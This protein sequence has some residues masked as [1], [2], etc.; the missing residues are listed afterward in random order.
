MF[1]ATS[2]GIFILA[3]DMKILA[4]NQAYSVITGRSSADAVGQNILELAGHKLKSQ[5]KNLKQFLNG[6]DRWQG[7]LTAKRRSG[8][9]FPIWLQLTVVRDRGGQITHYVG[10][11]ADLTTHRQTEEQLQYLTNYDALTQLA[12]RKLFNERLQQVAKRLSAAVQPQNLLARLSAD[13]FVVIVEHPENEQAL[14]MLANTLLHRLREPMLLGEQELVMTASIGISLFPATA[15][16]SLLLITQANQAMQHAKQLGGNNAQFF[17]HELR[18]YSL[19]QLQLENQLR[20]ALEDDQLIVYYQPKLHLATDRIRSA[21]ALVRWQH[22]ER[23]LVMPGE[24]INIAEESG[25]IV[26]LGDTVLRQACKQ[27]SQWYREGPTAVAVSVNLSVQQLRQE[28]FAQD[29]A[30]ILQAT[31][32]PAH[33]LEL[34]LTESMLLEHSPTVSANIAALKA[35]GIT[36]SVDDFGTGYSSLAYLKRFPISTL[37]IDRAFVAELDEKHSDDAIILAIIA[38]AHSLSLTVVAEG[39]EHESQM[40]FLKAN[41]CDEVQGYLISRPIPADEFSMLLNSSNEMPM[42]S[43][44]Y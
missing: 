17:T 24:F 9:H 32:L 34:E 14:S 5:F 41:G 39:V 19:D 36:L 40:A 30:Q 27:A 16:D 2:E 8:E 20:K 21:E 29:V 33:L 44:R 25:M 35:L 10:F 12:N 31:S 28:G 1:E 18:A 42:L 22:P 7:E 37:K 15:S 13:E 38:M 23:G 43:S 26:A 6:K 4:V 3:P 11:F